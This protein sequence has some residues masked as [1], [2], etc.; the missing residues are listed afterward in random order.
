MLHNAIVNK[1]FRQ[2]FDHA[3]NRRWDEL[4]KSIAP[5]VD[6]RFL[7]AH[8][9]AGERHDR[10]TLGRWF[11]RFAHVLPCPHLRNVSDPDRAAGA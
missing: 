10:E 5:D 11:E 8:A 9:I 7:G 6:H 2:A 4:M 3:N 1:T